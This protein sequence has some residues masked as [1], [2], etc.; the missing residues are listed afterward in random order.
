MAKKLSVT[1]SKNSGT[2][3][4][5]DI[6]FRNS[7]HID[8]GPL[9]GYRLWQAFAIASGDTLDITAVTVTTGVNDPMGGFVDP[10]WFRQISLAFIES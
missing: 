2:A 6:F 5:Q 3:T 1:A 8:G 10:D 7:E 4:S 9:F